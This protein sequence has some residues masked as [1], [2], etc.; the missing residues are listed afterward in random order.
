MPTTN[1]TFAALYDRLG[2]DAADEIIQTLAFA[3]VLYKE[4]LKT[5]S[6]E[7]GARIETL[8]EHRFAELHARLDTLE[9]ENI[10][11]YTHP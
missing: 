2:E 5:L 6:R 9:R 7:T 1:K 3:D 10:K 4:E 8:I 11:V